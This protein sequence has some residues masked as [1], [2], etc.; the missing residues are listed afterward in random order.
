EIGG[1]QH[2]RAKST[3][4]RSPPALRRTFSPVQPPTRTLSQDIKTPSRREKPRGNA[5]E[6]ESYFFNLQSNKRKT[7]V[8]LSKSC[9][10][11]IQFV[12][13]TE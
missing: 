7:V 11:S 4:A 13:I 10:L 6:R 5:P 2:S 1:Q 3:Q 8:H 12:S 9:L